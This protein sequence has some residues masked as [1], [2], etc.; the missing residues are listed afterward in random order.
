M[1]SGRK[2]PPVTTPTVKVF[3]SPPLAAL[4][5]VVPMMV[6]AEASVHSVKDSASAHAPRYWYRTRPGWRELVREKAMNLSPPLAQ[7]GPLRGSGPTPVEQIAVPPSGVTRS[8]RQADM[9]GLSA[10]NTARLP[11]IRSV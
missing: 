8:E 1:L 7:L 3:F 10:V 4:I 11:A 9:P 2:R 5:L 6:L